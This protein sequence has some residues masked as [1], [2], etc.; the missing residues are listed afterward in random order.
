MNAVV[1]CNTCDQALC[2]ECRRLIH[3]AKM[4]SK[5]GVV[6]VEKRAQK[7]KKFCGNLTFRINVFMYSRLNCSLWSEGSLTQLINDI[8][9]Y[10]L[11]QRFP[12]FFNRGPLI[13][14]TKHSVDPLPLPIIQILRSCGPHVGN[15]TVLL[16]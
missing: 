7:Q 10:L 1:F 5:H 16:A 6:P 4:F 8:F 15:Y 13:A 3:S 2:N 12:T 11:L 14:N 9:H